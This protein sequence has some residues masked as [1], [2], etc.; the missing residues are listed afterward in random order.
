M[1]DQNENPKPI[2]LP[3][4][5]DELIEVAK[6]V[7]VSVPESQFETVFLAIV[8]RVYPKV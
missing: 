2:K 7:A 6:K 4:R 1:N 8:E 5:V 3:E